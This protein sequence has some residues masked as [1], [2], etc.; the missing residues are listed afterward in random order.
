MTMRKQQMLPLPAPT[1]AAGP[2]QCQPSGTPKSATCL[3]ILPE[4]VGKHGVAHARRAKGV[5]PHVGDAQVQPHVQRADRGQRAAQAA[6]GEARR[7]AVSG[8]G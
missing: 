8:G 6:G 7:W 1:P 4:P 3:D 5:E 2:S